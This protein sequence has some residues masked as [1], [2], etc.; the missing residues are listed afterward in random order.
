MKSRRLELSSGEK[1]LIS[2]LSIL[3]ALLLA[4]L[5]FWIHRRIKANRDAKRQAAERE[6]ELPVAIYDDSTQDSNDEEDLSLAESDDGSM[7]DKSISMCRSSTMNT[8]DVHKCAS[9]SCDLCRKHQEPKFLGVKK[10]E[11]GTEGRI[12]SLP[13]YWWENPLSLSARHSAGLLQT[14]MSK[15]GDG[16]AREEEGPADV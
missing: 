16:G 2:G 1:G 8:L 14:I 4:L 15:S 9:G 3:A 13:D 5:G 11:P 12:R 10:V 6:K 7:N